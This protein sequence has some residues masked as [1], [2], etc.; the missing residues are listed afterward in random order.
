MT[1]QLQAAYRACHG[2]ARRSA[3]NFACAERFLPP[4]QRRGMQ[5][6]YAFARRCDDIADGP[7]PLDHR[8][9]RLDQWRVQL[10]A[11][12]AGHG[13]DPVLVA[14]ADTVSRFVVPQHLLWRIVDGVEMDLDQTSYATYAD[15]RRYCEHVA[16]AVGL[17]CLAIWG[18]RD[19]EAILPAADCGVAFQLTNILRDLQPDGRQGRIYLPHDELARFGVAPIDW[20]GPVGTLQLRNLLTFQCE[21]AAGLFDAGLRTERYLDLGPKRVFHLMW[22]TYRAI[23]AEIESDPLIVLQR[24]VRLSRPWKMWLAGRTMLIRA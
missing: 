23:L 19:D 16:S 1:P 20:L 4:D 2:A 14:V 5:A 17:A 12:L 22:T 13:D 15:L 3:S 10:R 6:L 7:E 8:R 11:A 18:C 21:R 9:Q 24:R